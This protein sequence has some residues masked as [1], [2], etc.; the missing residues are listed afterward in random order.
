M[1][2][3]LA[4][5]TTLALAGCGLVGGGGPD[6]DTVSVAIAEPAH[7]LPSA[8]ADRDGAQVLAALFTPLVRYD[9]ARRPT[10]AAAAAVT[11]KDNRTW[12][13]TLADGYTF[14][15]G[16]PVTAAD[17]VNAWNYA[18]YGPNRQRNA[19]LFD[20]VQ[21]FADIQGEAPPAKTLY[22]LRA[23]DDRTVEVRLATPFADF[24][25]MLGHPAFLPL[26]ASAFAAPGT[27]RAGFEDAV[28][29][30]GPYRMTG[31]WEHD[32]Q[33]RVERYAAYPAPPPVAKIQFRVYGSSGRAYRDL[34]DGDLDVDAALPAVELADA[35]A[36][37]GDRYAVTTGSTLNVLAFPEYQPGFADARVRRAVSMAL[38]RDA[39]VHRYFPG[40][41]EPA[42]SFVPP[43]VPGHRA[44]TCP[45]CRF[46]PGAARALYAE[47]KGPAELR[48][49]YN[50]DGGHEEWVTAACAQ[51]AANLAVACTPAPEK[52]FD[53]LLERVRRREPVGLFRMSWSMD[54]PSMES[55]L[56]PLFTTA[57]S[58]NYGGYQSAEVDTL[59]RRAAAAKNPAAAAAAYRQ[60]ED[61]LAGDMPVIPLRY[62]RRAVGHS[63]R[64]G[65]V[66]LDV[67]ETVDVTALTLR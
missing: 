1:R 47:A 5:A 18:A 53:A 21:G 41:E 16:S 9:E 24:P 12:R 60:I 26:P 19:Y 46:D 42:R 57:G 63:E 32:E 50:A 55:Y 20:R 29:G 59:A 61:Q 38:D 35:A 13:I 45:S 4:A 28:V 22:G 17:Y 33:V 54:Y 10:P 2:R 14:H 51:L 23:V 36:R 48:I 64:V 8:V 30:Q 56:T 52:S 39:L 66:R 43:V 67:Y 44:G 40:S 37:L 6:P 65:G 49:A 3:L 7:L 15:D 31:R 27:L 11:S 58:S 62:A 34:L 25:A